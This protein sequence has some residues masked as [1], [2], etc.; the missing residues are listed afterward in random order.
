MR[1][2]FLAA[3]NGLVR[4][5]PSIAATTQITASSMRPAR[6]V[7]LVLIRNSDSKPVQFD[8]SGFGEMK[9]IFVTIVQEA[10]RADRLEMTVRANCC[11]RFPACRAGAM[12]RRVESAAPMC[13]LPSRRVSR[14]ATATTI[15][16][17]ERFG[18]VERVLQLEGTAQRHDDFM[19]QHRVRWRGTDVEKK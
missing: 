14:R 8:T 2:F 13:L 18:P 5:K 3:L 9:N 12:G 4:N 16:D 19:W 6:D 10:L 11:S 7:T 1:S 17:R 15:V